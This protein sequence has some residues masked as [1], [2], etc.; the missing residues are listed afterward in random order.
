VT[1]RRRA[2]RRDLGELA[3]GD[4]GGHRR[5]D[6][7]VHARARPA[8]RRGLRRRPRGLPELGDPADGPDPADHRG[9]PGPRRAVP[10]GDLCRGLAL[11]ILPGYS[12]TSFAA[13]NGAFA[14]AEFLAALR[15]CSRG[16]STQDGTFATVKLL[17][18][19]DRRRRRPAAA[20]RPPGDRRGGVPRRRASSTVSTSGRSSPSTA[21]SPATRTL[22]RR[23]RR[24]GRTRR[25]PVPTPPTSSSTRRPIEH[26]PIG[27][28]ISVS[29]STRTPRWPRHRS[30]CAAA[31]AASVA[32]PGSASS[33]SPSTAHRGHA[34]CRARSRHR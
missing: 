15:H 11:A 18:Q 31:P 20:G 16:T 25:S 4:L 9:R 30:R 13:V 24:S 32:T 1:G 3:H 29:R 27:Y 6:P 8:T 2:P 23:L 33:T 19:E 21:T 7:R 22:L 34:G 28:R 5:R 12:P 17:P 10:P 26:L 14:D